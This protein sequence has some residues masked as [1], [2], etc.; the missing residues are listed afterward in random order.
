MTLIRVHPA[1]ICPIDGAAM[2]LR[3]PR[4]EDDWKPFWGCRNYPHC[5]GTVKPVTKLEDQP[6]FW[7]EKDVRYERI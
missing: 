6:S 7:E 5:N 4:P 2:V 1:P 3:R